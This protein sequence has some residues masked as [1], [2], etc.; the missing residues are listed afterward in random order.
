MPVSFYEQLI[1]FNCLFRKT[2]KISSSFLKESILGIFFSVIQVQK[3]EFNKL[4]GELIFEHS[5]IT[6]KTLNIML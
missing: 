4:N 1:T 6:G 3:W 5:L 2:Q